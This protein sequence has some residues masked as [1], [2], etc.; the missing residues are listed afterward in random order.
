MASMAGV[1]AGNSRYIARSERLPF[2]RDAVARCVTDSARPE[3]VKKRVSEWICV[4]S[5]I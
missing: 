5:R 3:S 2:F 4:K 1:A